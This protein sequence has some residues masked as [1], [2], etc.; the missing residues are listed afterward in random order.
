MLGGPLI[1]LAG[2]VPFLIYHWF[3]RTAPPWLIGMAVAVQ[4]A[5]ITWLATGRLARRYRVAAMAAVL[6]AVLGAMACLGLS[7]RSVGLAAGGLCHGAAYTALLAWFAL[8]LRP[9]GPGRPGHEPVV[10][11]FAR[12]MRRSMPPKVVRYTRMVTIAW[13]GFFA[14]QLAVSAS[15]LATA[16]VGVWSSFVNL[17]SLPLVAAMFLAEF[18]VRLVL[19]R[20][21][22]RTGL[23]ATLAGLRQSGGLRGGRS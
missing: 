20:R 3:S 10:T 21:E 19:F 23:I 13:C 1:I 18:S 9:S 8:S 11:R 7:A 12:Q 5:A 14:A 15:L 2:F 16:P 4:L 6:V 22:N 17:W